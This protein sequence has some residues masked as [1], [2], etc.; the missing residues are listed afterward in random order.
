MSTGAAAPVQ[1]GLRANWRQ[2]WLLVLVNAFVGAM[3]GLERTVVPLLADEAFG[4]AAAS[5]A[6]SFI[7]SFGIVKAFAN[8]FAGRFSDRVGRKHLLVIGWLFALPVP[9]I[10]ILAPS[11]WWIVFANVL[12][13]INQG[14]TWSMTVVMK[15]DLVGPVR[16]GLAMGLNEFAGYVA[17]AGSALLTGWLAQTYGLRPEPFVFGFGIALVGLLLSVLAVRETREHA[18]HEA[19]LSG[20]EV[21]NQQP[22]FWSI[23]TLTSWRNRNLFSCSQAG[24]VNNLNDGL[25]WGLLPLYFAAGGMSVGRIGVLAAV[26]P[27]VWG[28]GQLVTGLASDRLG[29][30]WLIAA[31][32]WTQALAI[33]LFVALGGFSAWIGA[34]ALLGVGTAMVYPTLLAAIADNTAPTWRGSAVGVYRLWRDSGYAAGA[35]LAGMV[36]DALGIDWAIMSI[37]ALTLASGVIVAIVMR[38]RR[39]G[40]DAGRFDAID[41]AEPVE[42]VTR[43][44]VAPS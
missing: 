23:F 15:I 31:G 28:V 30:K 16:R 24:M 20:S 19:R 25:A 37:A 41:H 42:P 36:A 32:M 26:Y 29:R 11:W 1:L 2:F 34:A 10:I 4:L 39:R 5:A 9:L 38:E 33:A 43:E 7:V 22:P 8:L 14:F 35:L 18:H 6:T 44:H 12:L 3:V 21:P 27:A 17:V 13:G 40:V